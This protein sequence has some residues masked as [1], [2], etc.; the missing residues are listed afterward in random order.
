MNEEEV[1]DRLRDFVRM[2]DGRVGLIYLNS[3]QGG[4]F[5]GHMLV[6]FGATACDGTPIVEHL[7]VHNAVPVMPA[8]A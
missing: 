7:P 1:T 8:R 6:W 4:V 2:P 3:A 5:R